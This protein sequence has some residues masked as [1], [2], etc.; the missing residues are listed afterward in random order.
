MFQL[1]RCLLHFGNIQGFFGMSWRKK[2]HQSQSVYQNGRT[3]TPQCGNKREES[4]GGKI[5]GSIFKQD[6][7]NSQKT[8]GK[9]R[10]RTS[11]ARKRNVLVRPSQ[12]RETNRWHHT[13]QQG[14]LSAPRSPWPVNTPTQNCCSQMVT[15]TRDAV[16]I[17]NPQPRFISQANEASG[18][19]VSSVHPPP[20]DNRSQQRWPFREDTQ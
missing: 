2:E 18:L 3:S 17:T 8:K 1:C 5:F 12:T 7:S 9:Y 4:C 16:V 13:Y 15:P 20:L 11:V 14:Q 10:S 19:A 6:G